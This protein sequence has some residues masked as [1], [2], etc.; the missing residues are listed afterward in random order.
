ME[1][2]YLKER[3]SAINFKRIV[4][5]NS[6]RELMLSKKMYLQKTP[7][8]VKCFKR[9]KTPPTP[10]RLVILSPDLYNFTCIG[11]KRNTLQLW[12]PFLVWHKIERNRSWEFYLELVNTV[13]H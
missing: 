4:H 11:P 1:G 12:K 3:G 7:I 2:F 13:L 6:L 5:H 8:R 9:Q 10:P